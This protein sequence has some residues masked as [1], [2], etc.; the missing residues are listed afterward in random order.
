MTTKTIGGRR[1]KIEI[2]EIGS[3]I[4]IGTGREITIEIVAKIRTVRT[5]ILTGIIEIEIVRTIRGAMMM[6]GVAI[7]ISV[8]VT[9]LPE[10]HPPGKIAVINLRK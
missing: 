8:I 6:I 7:G 2:T 9:D 4:A 5:E 3:G 1:K 10:G